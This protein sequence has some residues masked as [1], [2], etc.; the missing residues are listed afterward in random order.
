MAK[1]RDN[2][3]VRGLQST[4]TLW[5]IRLNHMLWVITHFN[6]IGPFIFLTF[7]V[8]LKLIAYLYAL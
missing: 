2:V 3:D 4:S 5:R 1:S 8:S 7:M 6:H